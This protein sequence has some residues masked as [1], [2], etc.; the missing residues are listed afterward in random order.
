M[1]E[2]DVRKELEVLGITV[3]LVLQLRSHRRTIYTAKDNLLTPHFIVT[4]LRGPMVS[5]VRAPIS[6][7]GLRTTL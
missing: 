6:L 5:K 2:S 1:P 3:V 7:C 4:V